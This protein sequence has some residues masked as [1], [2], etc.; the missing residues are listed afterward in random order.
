MIKLR[1]IKVIFN[2]MTW[3]AFTGVNT[4]EKS[5][6]NVIQRSTMMKLV[7]WA[8]LTPIILIKSVYF[9]HYALSWRENAEWKTMYSNEARQTELWAN[10]VGVSVFAC[11]QTFLPRDSFF[12]YDSRAQKTDSSGGK[13][14][15]VFF[16]S[17]Q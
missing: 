17:F 2:K 1:N 16:V 3:I 7:G 6:G 10:F 15:W 14:L 8:N 4:S 13:W 9:A 12:V 5:R 11:L